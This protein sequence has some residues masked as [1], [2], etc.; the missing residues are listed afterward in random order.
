MCAMKMRGERWRGKGTDC[1]GKAALGDVCGAPRGEASF[2]LVPFS[3]LSSFLP[4]LRS[5]SRS[6]LAPFSL[7]LSC[8]PTD[9][10]SPFPGRPHIF[11]GRDALRGGTWLGINA[12]TGRVAWVTN[13]R[14]TPD[15]W[16]AKARSRGA[17][18]MDCLESPLDGASFLA[19]IDGSEYAG[20]NLV[21]ADVG[22]AAGASSSAAQ[23]DASVPVG[24]PRR[25]PSLVHGANREIRAVRLEGE[26]RAGALSA[27]DVDCEPLTTLVSSMRSAPVPVSRVVPHAVA[28]GAHTLSNATMDVAWPKCHRV[29]AAFER[30]LEEA[31][32]ADVDEDAKRLGSSETKGSVG[33]A[34]NG[35]GPRAELDQPDANAAPRASPSPSSSALF[36]SM[37]DSTPLEAGHDV[38]FMSADALTALSASFV[39]PTRLTPTSGRYGTR[40][41]TFVSIRDDGKTTVRERAWDME[42]ERWTETECVFRI[43]RSASADEAEVDALPAGVPASPCL[44]SWRQKTVA[45]PQ[46]WCWDEPPSSPESCGGCIGTDE[47]GDASPPDAKSQDASAT[48]DAGRCTEAPL[49]G[50]AHASP[51]EAGAGAAPSLDAEEEVSKT[52]DDE[53][54]DGRAEEETRA[55]TEEVG[56]ELGG[57]GRSTKGEAET[58][59]VGCGKA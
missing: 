56:L 33:G 49:A 39:A 42:A 54:D 38:G 59:G 11:G 16:P 23:G 44:V 52:V 32:E 36:S 22:V 53:E 18:L 35:S 47:A 8:S 6:F 14:E 46:G 7:S 1:A 3:P 48:A 34:A 58:V 28:A 30:A 50:S 4:A 17:L 31:T 19:S 24:P 55:P 43:G 37:A 15:N 29:R 51:P 2:P 13:V 5:S 26:A 9:A 20:F 27:L 10:F 40:S 12:A 21:I 41:Q 25:V 57:A 45:P